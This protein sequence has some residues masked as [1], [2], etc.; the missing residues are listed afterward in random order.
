MALIDEDQKQAVKDFFDKLTDLYIQ[1]CDKMMVYFPNIDGFNC[2]DD[3]GSQKET[4][5]SPD[6]VEEMIVPYMRRL[7]TISTPRA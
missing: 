4:F 3:W 2:H 7:T 1:I 5:F 6:I